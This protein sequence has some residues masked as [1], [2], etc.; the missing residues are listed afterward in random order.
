MGGVAGHAS[1]TVHH[2]AIHPMPDP[3]PTT[4]RTAIAKVRDQGDLEAFGDLVA[5][6]QGELKG[7][8]AYL[9]VGA[10]DIDELAQDTFVA[11]FTALETY[12]QDAPFA[13]WLRGIARNR[14]LRKRT[15]RERHQPLGEI[16][17]LEELLQRS[18]PENDPVEPALLPHLAECLDGLGATAQQLVQL[19]YRQSL[20]I[21]RIAAQVGK[22]LVAVRVALSRLRAALKRCIERRAAGET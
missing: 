8:L 2:R 22:E 17:A 14:V 15:R 6:H 3:D 11:A 7:F 1:G 4:V 16:A 13:P 5:W 18:A 21:E 9:G 12:D 10:G 19:R 20:P